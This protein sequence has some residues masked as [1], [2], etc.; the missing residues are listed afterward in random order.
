MPAP[1]RRINRYVPWI[2]RIPLEQGLKFEPTWKAL[3]THSLTRRVWVERMRL[4]YLKVSK[5]RSSFTSF[6]H[7]LGAFPFLLGFCHSQGTLFS[8][9]CLWAHRIHYAFD[10]KNKTFTP[11]DL[12]WFERRIG[13]FLPSCDDLGIPPITGQLGCSLEGAGK[14]RIFAIGNYINQR[15]LKPV[16]QWFASVLRGIPMDG[17]F[18]QTKPFVRLIPSYTCFSYDLKSATDRWPLYYMSE[19]VTLLFDR[20]FASSVV[21]S[22]LGQN[23]FTI[24]FVRRP[25]TSVCFQTGQPLGYYGSWP[26]FAFTH[27]LFV[28]VVG[29]GTG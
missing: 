21:N 6:C 2:K 17:T 27:H 3:P 29:C 19:V 28:G 13:P 9:G 14:R 23:I 1:I 4:Q 12:D 24:P 8:Q 5:S 15:L 7:E 16:H 25:M 10:V 18:N 20:S 11:E 22:T 26:I